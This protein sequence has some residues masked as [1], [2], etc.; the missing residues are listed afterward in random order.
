MKHHQNSS[1]LQEKALLYAVGALPEEERRDYARHLQED[2]CDI[3]LAESLEF[4]NAAQTLALGLP[5]ETPSGSVKE[6]LMAQVRADAGAGAAIQRVDYPAPAR[7]SGNVWF[8]VEKLLL[9]TAVVVLAIT[10]TTNASLRR[11]IERLNLR[12]SDLDEQVR[13]ANVE[14]ARFRSPLI[15]VVNL[16]GQGATPQ[17]RARIFWNEMDRVWTLYVANLPPA[18]QDRAYQLWFVPKGSNPVSA[19]VF[20][21]N[22]DGTAMFDINLPAGAT[23]FVAAAIT[24]EPAGGLPQPTG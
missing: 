10:A 11:E 20:N 14:L 13:N 16:T 12:V 3:C 5:A 24:P 23:D 18:P 15:R 4:Q 2:G 21:T 6:R 19:L 22:A 8:W 7:P 17:A 1:E 9:A